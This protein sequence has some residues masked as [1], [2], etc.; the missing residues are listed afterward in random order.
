MSDLELLTRLVVATL[1][2]GAL[3]LERELTAKPAGLRTHMLVAEGA[4]LF[5]LASLLIAPYGGPDNP[6]DLSRIAANV[7]TGVGF[8]GGGMILRARDRVY[9]LTTA[10]GIWVAAAIG[11]LAGAG[12]YFLAVAGTVVGLATITAGR[13]VE[14][15]LSRVSRAGV[16][17]TAEPSDEEGA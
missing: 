4:A 5:M 6:T 15:R 11:M 14:R 3:G 7:V 13:W 9:G 10:A 8:L 1:L 16:G 12:A 17:E 2:G